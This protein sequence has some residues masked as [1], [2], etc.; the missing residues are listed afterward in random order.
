M[1]WRDKQPQR[2]KLLA[3]TKKN[4]GKDFFFTVVCAAT[5]EHKAFRGFGGRV[6]RGR[7]HGYVG[8]L[9]IRIEFNA[10]GH[11]DSVSRNT[12][13]CPSFDVALFWYAH[14]IKEAERW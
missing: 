2:W 6:P 7:R 4:P 11:V 8:C 3:Q 14:Q 13:R 9:N 5:K 1:T 10:A 12:E